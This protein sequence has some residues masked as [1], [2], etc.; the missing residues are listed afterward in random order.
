MHAS[1]CSWFD[2]DKTPQPVPWEFGVDRPPVANGEFFAALF[3]ELEE[4]VVV[5]D[6]S[7]L[8][9]LSRLRVVVTPNHWE[10]P[11]TGPD[12]VAVLV[13]DNWARVPRW[14][15]DVGL[16]LAT[17]R[18]RAW[19]DALSMLPRPLGALELLD[20]ARV[21]L[22][23]GMWRRRGGRRPSGR[24]VL[25][26]PL[27]YA[28]QR[29]VPQVPWEDR[30]VD[31]F[32]AG[33]TSHG[34]DKGG[35]LRRTLRRSVGNV[36]TV[37]RERMTDAVAQ[38][39]RAEPGLR[40]QVDLVDGDRAADHANSYSTNM[41]RSRF[42]LDP[43]G[44][45]RETYRFYEA[46]RTGT[47][48]VVTS[49]PAGGLYRGAPAVRLRHWSDLPSAMRSLARDPDRAR[50]LHEACL[51]WYAEHGGPE[52]TARRLLPDVVRLLRTL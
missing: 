46:V 38:L 15:D 22:E 18:D 44:T 13:L 33:S 30:D 32:F 25:A 41:A 21:R 11:F 45:S 51:S 4:M 12:V 5:A 9:P 7:L 8:G 19:S 3:T 50:E 17:N 39:R 1:Y 24:N 35:R 37:H 40:V 36:K 16:V 23:R 28:H 48:P 6:G 34:L 2:Q 47:V 31:V 27:G 43:R 42:C 20:E 26:L 10:L 29:E 49:L 14:A 52:A